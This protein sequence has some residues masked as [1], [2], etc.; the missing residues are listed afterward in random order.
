MTSYSKKYE[1][2]F[3]GLANYSFYT[4]VKPFFKYG[5]LSYKFITCLFFPPN[6]FFK[7]DKIILH[8]NHIHSNQMFVS[9]ND[10]R[11]VNTIIFQKI[12]EMY[13]SFSNDKC[14]SLTQNIHFQKLMAWLSQRNKLNQT[15]NDFDKHEIGT[16]NENRNWLPNDYKLF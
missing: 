16:P 8:N 14:T 3:A 7:A 15:R 2:H 6:V 9:E 5:F 13:F 4:S 10:K 1:Y 11:N 12:L